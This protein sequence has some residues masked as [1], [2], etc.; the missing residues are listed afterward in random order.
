M[1][2]SGHV[3]DDDDDDDGGTLSSFRGMIDAEGIGE[4]GAIIDAGGNGGE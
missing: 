4:C 3:E 1:K 2:L